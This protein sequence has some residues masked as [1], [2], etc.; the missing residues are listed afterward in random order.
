MIMK[1]ITPGLSEA[2]FDP[3]PIRQFELWYEE[4]SGSFTGEK[5]AMALSTAE[6]GGRVSSRMVLMKNYDHSGFVFFT[7]YN[8]KKGRQISEN[9]FG[10][11]L[12]YWP[13]QK[14]QV[15][16]EGRIGKVSSAISEE[17]FHSRPMESQYSAAASPQ[18][19]VIADKNILMEKVRQL[20]LL[21]EGRVPDRPGH[22]GGYMLEPDYFEFWQEGENRLH[23]RIIYSLTSASWVIKRLAP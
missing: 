16:I 10:S 14:R 15:R 9:P 1:N 6:K 17:Y 5:N 21:Y 7:S 3:D 22:W 4:H 19:S 2:S 8:S 12:F 23:D 20:H 18:S 13:E 11:L